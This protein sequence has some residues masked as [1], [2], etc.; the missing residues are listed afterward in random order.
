MGFLSGALD[1][2][3]SLIGGLPGTLL[4]IGGDYA[5]SQMVGGKDAAHANRLAQENSAIAWNNSLDLYAKRYR[6]TMADM[7][8][9]G[10]NPI[11]AAASGGF[12]VS[13]QPSYQRAEAF[14]PHS[15]YGGGSA[16]A[17]NFA[18]AGK[19]TEETQKVKQETQKTIVEAYHEVKKINQ[20]M[21]RTKLLTTEERKAMQNIFNLEQ[22]FFKKAAEISKLREE[23][24]YVRS[25]T[26]AT[27]ADIT[28]IG[29][30]ERKL[31]AE[32]TLLE[33]KAKELQYRLSQ[34]SKLA[35]VYEGPAG[36][37]LAYVKEIMGALN[38]NLGLLGGF[39]K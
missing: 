27:Q 30:Q 36:Q 2:G 7:K 34:L 19:A 25:S 12:N 32:G 31:Q 21:A 5:A 8:A 14:M 26:A 16:S 6:Y 23:V 22:E 15:P 3:K 9:A 13:G 18:Q 39:K 20:T 17:L 11:L 33:K 35:K 37:T 4:G 38:L 1:F 29:A 24:Q 10:L 28:R